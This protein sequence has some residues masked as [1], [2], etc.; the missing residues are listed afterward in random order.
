MAFNQRV[1]EAA[2]LL[3][4]TAFRIS[5]FNTQIKEESSIFSLISAFIFNTVIQLLVMCK[6][7]LRGSRDQ[8]HQEYFLPQTCPCHVVVITTWV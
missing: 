6:K 1:S 7:F 8:H 2:A 4:I 3:G 5:T